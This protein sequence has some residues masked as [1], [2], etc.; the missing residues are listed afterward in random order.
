MVP[1]VLIYMLISTKNSHFLVRLP[2]PPQAS[3][4]VPNGLYSF[5][6]GQIFFLPEHPAKKILPTFH[7]FLVL[8]SRGQD[9]HDVLPS[10]KIT[11]FVM[12]SAVM[13]SSPRSGEI[14][15]IGFPTFSTKNIVITCHALTA[16]RQF[17]HALSRHALRLTPRGNYALN[18]M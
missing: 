15:L 10:Q 7:S 11:D 18:R 17:C 16:D 5:F 1:R 3:R 6:C 2:E 9:R 12:P 4:N 14:F 13:P 8:P